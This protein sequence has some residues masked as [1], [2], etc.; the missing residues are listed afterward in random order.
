MRPEVASRQWERGIALY[1]A[2]K[3]QQ[4]AE[5][6][7]LYQTYHNSDVENSVW[8]FLCMVPDGGVE[9]ARAA[10][11]PIQDDRRV[12]MME[13]FRLFRGQIQPE[14]VLAAVQRSGAEPKNRAAHRFYADLYLGLYFDALGK[15]AQAREHIGRAAAVGLK[16]NPFLNR[17]MWDVARI[18]KQKHTRETSEESRSP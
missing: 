15:S 2:G 6:F 8:R 9:K 11:L 16:K 14:E 10:M 5:Q 12:P 7:E 18:H 17:Y 13:I 1:Y 4:G 3:Y